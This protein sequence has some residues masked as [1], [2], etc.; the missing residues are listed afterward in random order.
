MPAAAAAILF[1]STVSASTGQRV[2]LV[3]GNAS[4]QH[5]PVLAN[6]LNDAAD[7][8]ATLGRLGFTVTFMENADRTELWSGLQQFSMTA[9]AS[10]MAVVFYAGHGV[11]VDKRNFLVPVDARLLSDADIEFETVPLELVSRAVEPARG[12]RLIILDACR[13]NPFTVAMQRTGATRSIGR[14]LARV[15]P[16]GGTLVSYAAKE[17]TVAADGMGRNSP[18]TTALLAHLE[19]PGLEVGLM[20]RKVRDAVLAATGGRQEPFIYGSM[21]SEGAYLA[22]L[23]GPEP[24]STPALQTVTVQGGEEPKNPDPDQVVEQRIAA[25]KELLFWESV[26]DSTHAADFE[27]YLE[28]FPGGTYEALA[29]NRLKRLTE[30]QDEK[31]VVQVAATPDEPDHVASPEPAQPTPEAIEAALSLE[32]DERRLIQRGLASLG[33]DP[34]PA[35]GLFG[36]RTRKALKKWQSS[37]KMAATGHLDA[38]VAKVLLTEAEA[39]VRQQEEGSHEIKRETTAVPDD[40]RGVGPRLIIA[41]ECLHGEGAPHCRDTTPVFDTISRAETTRDRI[42]GFG[43]ASAG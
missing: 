5:A 31:P 13:D 39:A 17:G 40:R 8:G 6:P 36:L 32:R 30:Q 12:F 4:Y 28:Q 41:N 34:G 3:I 35:D 11:E 2:A 21:S 9:S 18:Y 22:A 19:E 43:R 15:E 24:E 25:E 33:F 14:G 38:E 42:G 16:S 29:R 23:P 37:R 27:A 10:E 26:K 20:F 7:I 1:A